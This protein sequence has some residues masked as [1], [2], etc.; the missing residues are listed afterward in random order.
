MPIQYRRIIQVSLRILAYCFLFFSLPFLCILTVPSAK[1]NVFHEQFVYYIATED[2]RSNAN[3]IDEQVRLLMYKTKDMVRN[4]TKNE[5]IKDVSSYSLIEAGYGYCDQQ[6]NLFLAI[7]KANDISGRCVYLY[8]DGK[9]SHHTVCELYYA[10][11]FH[12]FDPFNAFWFIN[13]KGQIASMTEIVSGEI[14]TV[15]SGEIPERAVKD[16]E[17]G[18]TW[19]IGKSFD[20]SFHH[21]WQGKLMK[22]YYAVFGAAFYRLWF[23]IFDRRGGEILE[24]QLEVES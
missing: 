15:A 9:K 16:F 13:K 3:T 1:R 24:W 7:C 22:V 19:Q 6:V 2:C 10:D 20:A 14:D 23:S 17:S 5:D 4:P 21:E 18:I 12:L 8:R 11:D